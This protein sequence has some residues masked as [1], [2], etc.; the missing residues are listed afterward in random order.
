MPIYVT[1]RFQVK[2][3]SL[4]KAKRA[5][6]TFIA[7]IQKNEPGT[8]LYTSLQ[9]GNDPT[10]FLHYF[11]FDDAD[12]E[13]RHKTSEGVKDFTRILYPELVSDGVVFTHYT[14]AVSTK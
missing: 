6:E 10:V 2:P 13:E 14:L 9:D 8:R 1:A 11:I 12:A 3:E 7:Y 4:E 5:I